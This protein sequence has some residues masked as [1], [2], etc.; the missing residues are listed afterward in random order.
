VGPLRTRRAALP[1]LLNDL[2]AM[3]AAGE[4]VGSQ[5][6]RGSSDLRT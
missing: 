6:H 1:A 3:F 2:A 4:I 5:L